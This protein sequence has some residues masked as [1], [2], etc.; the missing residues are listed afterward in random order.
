MVVDPVGPPELVCRVHGSIRA[1]TGVA[2]PSE[3]PKSE[4]TLDARH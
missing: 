2:C 1:P 3:Q 4:R